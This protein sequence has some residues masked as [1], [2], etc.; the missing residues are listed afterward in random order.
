[1]DP[2]NRDIEPNL[3]DDPENELAGSRL[4]TALRVASLT[5]VAGSAIAVTAVFFAVSRNEPEEHLNPSPAPEP[6]ATVANTEPTEPA[7]QLLDAQERVRTLEGQLATAEAQLVEVATAAGVQPEELGAIDLSVEVSALRANLTAARQVRDRL[8]TDLAAALAAVDDQSLQTARAKSVALSWKKANSR[9]QWIAFA[10]DT[11]VA[12]CDHGT[13]KKVDQ[14]QTQVDAYFTDARFA[15]YA[16]CVEGGHATPV[17]LGT[18][19]GAEVPQTAEPL[20]GKQLPRNH[21]WYV[22]Y[23]DPSLPERADPSIDSTQLVNVEE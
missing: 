5:L 21:A 18:Q 15:R 16:E 12:L 9:S 3:N 6:V 2:F 22:L 19:K 11:K 7:A 8:R 13:R 23:C 14:C 17:L 1:M 10:A 4:Q 20:S